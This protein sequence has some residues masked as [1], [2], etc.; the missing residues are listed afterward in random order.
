MPLKNIPDHY[1]HPRRLPADRHR[2]SHRHLPHYPAPQP[3]VFC[4]AYSAQHNQPGIFRAASP[5][6]RRNN[7]PAPTSTGALHVRGID[8]QT[9][10]SD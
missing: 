10:L 7:A 6:R 4:P 8:P 3:G 2:Q 9:S 5:A 1:T